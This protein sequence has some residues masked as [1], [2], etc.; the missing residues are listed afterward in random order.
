LKKLRIEN[1]KL[2]SPQKEFGDLSKALSQ[3]FLN[4]LFSV[5]LIAIFSFKKD[6]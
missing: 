6:L 2:E 3:N 1:K 4:S 5:N